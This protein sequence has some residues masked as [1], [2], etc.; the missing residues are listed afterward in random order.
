MRACSHARSR[1]ACAFVRARTRDH[2]GGL[3]PASRVCGRNG[4]KK[5]RRD[6]VQVYK[7]SWKG[8]DLPLSPFIRTAAFFAFLSPIPRLYSL[9][10]LL[11]LG[12]FSRVSA[13]LFLSSLFVSS[14]LS[15][16]H[17]SPYFPS[18]ERRKILRA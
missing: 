15:F 8:G 2:S 12:S 11:L 13:F 6:R 18:S 14:L 16:S 3:C 10:R 17:F 4:E 7:G 9:S 5:A 1:V